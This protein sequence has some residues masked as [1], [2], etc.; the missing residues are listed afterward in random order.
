M[1]DELDTAPSTE[2][3]SQSSSDETDDF[4]AISPLLP[5]PEM[6]RVRRFKGI[7]GGEKTRLDEYPWLA[8]LE[9]SK[10]KFSFTNF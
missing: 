3:T 1:S 5:T 4:A 2:S 6:C 9:Y 7:V 10:R 8:L